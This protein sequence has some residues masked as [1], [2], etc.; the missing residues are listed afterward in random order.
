[1]ADIKSLAVGSTTVGANF[2]QIVNTQGLGGRTIIASVAKGTGDMTEAELVALTKALA[3]AG[4][5]GTGTDV[6]GPDAFTVVGIADFDG[7]D[8]V[9]I[10]VQ[11]TGTLGTSSGDYVTDITVTPVATF[12]LAN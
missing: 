5:D 9:Y 10:A 12:A 3:S 1:M 8:P 2:E 7:T 4:G 11:G 6:N